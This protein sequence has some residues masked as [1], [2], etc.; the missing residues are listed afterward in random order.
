MSLLSN[1]YTKLHNPLN[2]IFQSLPIVDGLE[3]NKLLEFLEILLRAKEFPGMSD[4]ILLK[5]IF[6]QCR[7][8]LLE[9]LLAYLEGG[10]NFDLFHSRLLQ[11]HGEELSHFVSNVKLAAKVLKISMTEREIVDVILE[12]I[13]PESR[14]RLLFCHRPTSF[15]E[16][17]QMCATVGAVQYNDHLSGQQSKKTRQVPVMQ[18]TGPSG[19]GFSPRL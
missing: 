10:A 2:S 14:A 8:P 17:S 6:P 13:T 18:I 11:R 5:Y 15:G 9:I 12:C 1:S 3:A 7:S 19:G 4:E 16:L